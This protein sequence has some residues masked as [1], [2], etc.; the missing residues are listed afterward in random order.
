MYLPTYEHSTVDDKVTEEL[1]RA[2]NVVA[3][4]WARAHDVIAGIAADVCRLYRSPMGATGV[5]YGLGFG[6][7]ADDAETIAAF[8]AMMADS[9]NMIKH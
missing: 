9:N 8:K 3:D 2:K 5:A 4:S 1:L 6:E 7:G